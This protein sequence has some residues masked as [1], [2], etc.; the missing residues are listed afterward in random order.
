MK[1]LEDNE[2][3]QLNEEEVKVLLDSVV[4]DRSGMRLAI[5]N[6]E[7]AVISRADSKTKM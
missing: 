4:F 1:V 5:S 3:A 2:D 7:K 6:L